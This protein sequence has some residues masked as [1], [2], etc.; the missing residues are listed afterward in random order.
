MLSFRVETKD[1]ASDSVGGLLHAN[2]TK[3][4]DK[5]YPYHGYYFRCTKSVNLCGRV[6]YN[7]VAEICGHEH[8]G[9]SC[10]DQRGLRECGLETK[11][12]RDLHP[13]RAKYRAKRDLGC[14]VRSG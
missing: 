12:A 1:R 2:Y 13:S 14:K 5:N 8:K 11:Q 6:E 3:L 10:I 4:E 7:S 9:T